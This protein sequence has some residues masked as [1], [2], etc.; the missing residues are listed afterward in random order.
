MPL[1]PLETTLFPAD[2]FEQPATEGEARW[3]ALH[4]RP[5]AE[6]MLARKFLGRRLGFFLPLQHRQRRHRGR[7]FA[8]D[9]PLFPGYLFLHGDAQARLHALETNA[10]VR[11]LAVEDQQ[12]LHADL[13]RVH[14]LIASGADLTPEGR[15]Q[16]GSPVEVVAGPLA[17]LTG[18]VL[19]QGKRLTFFVEV[20]LLQRGVSVE[21]EGWMIRALDERPAAAAARS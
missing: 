11:C 15:L 12:R 18:K 14:R 21:V 3:W 2:L 5:R 6:K 16:P 7:R 17:G 4:T 1:V 20:Q 19:R 13:L 10:I 9:L 8:A